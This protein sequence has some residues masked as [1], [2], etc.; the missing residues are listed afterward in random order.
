MAALINNAFLRDFLAEASLN[1]LGPGEPN[2][3]LIKKVRATK[4]TDIFGG[5]SIRDE[6]MAN[7]LFAGLFLLA[8]DLDRSH[9][10]SQD[11]SSPTGSYWH[12]IMHRREPDYGNAKYWFHRV[13]SHPVYDDVAPAARELLAAQA[14]DI[15]GAENETDFLL[16]DQWDAER[17]VDLCAM[18]TKGSKREERDAALENLCRQIQRTECELL[19][20]YCYRQAIGG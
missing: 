4:P 10:F 12:G 14:G 8:D 3:E 2:R 7:A 18:A 11:I 17:F 6:W 15:P 5:A 19:L 1:P 13:G 9:D 16:S 20:A